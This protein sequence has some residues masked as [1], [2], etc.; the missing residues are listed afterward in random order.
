MADP[1][2]D[3]PDHAAGLGASLGVATAVVYGVMVFVASLPG[4][5]VLLITWLRRDV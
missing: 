4:A 2:V 5:A 1:A 3:V